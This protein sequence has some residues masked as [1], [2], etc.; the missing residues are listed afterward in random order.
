[1][2]KYNFLF[3]KITF[4]IFLIIGTNVFASEEIKEKVE[5]GSE[6]KDWIDR[7]KEE[8]RSIDL[9]EF[10]DEKEIKSR[11]KKERKFSEK[12]IF[13]EIGIGLSEKG[14]YLDFIK[15]ANKK[16]Q[17]GLRVNYL[18]EDFFTHK[19]IYVDDRNIKAEY[20]GLGMLFQHNF[21]SPESRSNFYVRANADISSFKLFHNIDLSKEKRIENNVEY[22]CPGC[23]TLT[24]ET[25]PNKI[26]FV[27]SF[28]IGYQ[29]KNTPN[30]RTNI[31]LG[32]QYVLP[33]NV[34]YFTTEKLPGRGPYPSD[35]SDTI[36][37]RINNYVNKTQN[38]IDKYSEFQPSI[39]IGFSY[40]F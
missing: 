20:L 30:L 8:I 19:E 37:S 5:Q 33:G 25:D 15:N 13:E 12:K 26:Y 34:R 28:H 4:F 18:P 35:W 9:S 40:A 21:L 24:I 14:M 29:F 1:V 27:P 36:N 3:F 7:V 22:S 17:Y 23:G 31:S 16:N 10:E 32:I 38:K 2:S 39:N 11:D 6:D